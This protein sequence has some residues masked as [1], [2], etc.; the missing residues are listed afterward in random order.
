MEDRIHN[1]EYKL[2]NSLKNLSLSPPRII[3]I[4]GVD[5]VGKSA[6]ACKIAKELSVPHIEIDAF[7]QNQQGGYIKYIDYDRLGE[8]IV[9]EKMSNHT[10]VVEGI[11]VLQILNRLNL[12]SDVSVYVK[13]IDVYGF[14]THQMLL[15]PPDKSADEVISE[16]KAKRFLLGHKEDI[17]RYHYACR[18]HENADY[19]LERRSKKA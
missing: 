10:V 12:T 18:P 13:V 17:I 4:D 6:L 5:G 15:F 19:I 3:S 14:W 9:H 2:I 16:R 8:K 7:V 11:C 1:D